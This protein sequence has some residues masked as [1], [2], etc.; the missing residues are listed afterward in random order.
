MPAA[1]AALREKAKGQRN[2]IIGEMALAGTDGQQS[3]NIMKSSKLS[4]LSQP[5]H[6]EVDIFHE[7]NRVEEAVTVRTENLATAYRRLKQAYQFQLPFLT[8]D[9]QGLD[10]EIVSGA[11]NVLREF[12]GLQ[13]ELAEI[14]AKSNIP[15]D[16]SCLV[17][18]T[19]FNA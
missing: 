7:V 1:A 10:V 2:W 12:I 8:L 14:L 19:F 9:A 3:F 18:T 11:K 15:D 6:D 5:R 17:H 16:S 4:S 13:S